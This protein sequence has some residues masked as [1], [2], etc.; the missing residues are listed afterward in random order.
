M[1]CSLLG[2]RRRR[3][4]LSVGIS[5]GISVGLTHPPT[6]THPLEW[7]YREGRQ[8]GYENRLNGERRTALSVV[9]E[10]VSPTDN[11][12]DS[13]SKLNPLLRQQ[14][15]GSDGGPSRQ[16]HVFGIGSRNPEPSLTLSTRPR[17][18]RW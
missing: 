12:T 4:E 17:T 10:G 3:S 5:V 13:W 7:R 14:R 11:P 2:M 1:T 8:F 9:G 6:D 18:C 15:V 16:G